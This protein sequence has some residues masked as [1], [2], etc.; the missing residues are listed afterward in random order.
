MLKI[1]GMQKLTLLD[2]P[3]HVAADLF[4]AGCNFRCPFCQ[5][6]PLVLSPGGLPAY[7][8]EEVL[9][10]LK[11][12]QGI[13]DGICITGGE[14]T[15]YADLPELIALIRDMGYLVKLDTNGTNPDMLRALLAGHM[16]DYVA[17]DLKAGRANYARVAG[18]DEDVS[19]DLDGG[20][21]TDFDGSGSTDFDDSAST[22]FNGRESTDF[23]G[24]V[25]T[26]FG[27]DVSTDF[28]GNASTDFGGG[29]STDFDGGASRDLNH[30]ASI[31]VHRDE[32]PPKSHAKHKV[33]GELLVRVSQTVEL[34]LH[35]DIDYEFRTTVVKGL[36]DNSDFVD[37]ANWV[38]GCKRYYLQSFRDCD[39]ILLRDHPFSAFSEAQMQE[40]LSIVRKK[41]PHAQLRGVS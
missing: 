16:L 4:L 15:L 20:G 33:A 26:D 23:G 21:N 36:H 10:F 22:D 9:S 7:E 18:L 27:G 14:P 35:S 13:L 39:E 3:E 41:I 32:D 5:N 25:S 17:V 11:K 19:I 28:G 30:S 37:I 40:F 6:S 31:V 34:L 2:Y 29:G 8:Q 1:A 24:D 12:R 38:A